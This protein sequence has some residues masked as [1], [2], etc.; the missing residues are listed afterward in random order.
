MPHA[1]P[2]PCIGLHCFELRI[3]D[4]AKNWRIVY[5]ID[6]DAIVLVEV[7]SK[8]S[9]KLPGEVIDVC[10]QRLRRYDNE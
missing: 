9:Q 10:R 4:S 2:L 5:R 6:E 3:K 1:R 7:F 8:K